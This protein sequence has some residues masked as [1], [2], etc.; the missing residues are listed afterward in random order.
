MIPA[1]GPPNKVRV[2][3]GCMDICNAYDMWCVVVGVGVGQSV[4]ICACVRVCR[5]MGVQMCDSV[6]VC[7]CVVVWRR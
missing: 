4:G 1:R 3:D 6:D 5:Y 2:L 7:G